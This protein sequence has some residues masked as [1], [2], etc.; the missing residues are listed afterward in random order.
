MLTICMHYVLLIDFIYCTLQYIIQIFMATILLN[1]N[2][3]M[4]DFALRPS[5]D[6]FFV[7]YLIIS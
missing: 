7:R 6:F 2:V 1:E 5:F 3:N 4:S